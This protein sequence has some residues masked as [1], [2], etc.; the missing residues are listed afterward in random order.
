MN[1]HIL[2][3]ADFIQDEPTREVMGFSMIAFLCINLLTNIGFIMFGEIK[4]TYFSF[5][6]K[7]YT[8]K[9]IKM[10]KFLKE[11]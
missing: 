6:L 7:Y 9:L 5:R 11:K 4:K 1:Y 10:K 2:C 8:W 3:F